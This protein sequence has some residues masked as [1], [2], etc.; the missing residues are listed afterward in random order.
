MQALDTLPKLPAPIMVIIHPVI[1]P[2]WISCGFGD[3]SGEGCSGKLDRTDLL[4][5]TE[6]YILCNED[7]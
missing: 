2:L 1:G 3:A 4:A 6:I 5:C 7:S